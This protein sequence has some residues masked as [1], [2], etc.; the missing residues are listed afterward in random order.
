MRRLFKYDGLL[1]LANKFIYDNGLTSNINYFYNFGSLL[2]LILII[3]IISGILLAFNYIPSIELAFDSIEY[4]MR[5]IN[6]GYLIR[7]V[8]INGAN[9]FFIFV[10]LHIARAFLYGSFSLNSGR[11]Y[12]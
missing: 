12:S 2:G 6:Y 11:N 4:L 3:Q 10:Y 5:E 8:H 7:Y 1:N 9:F